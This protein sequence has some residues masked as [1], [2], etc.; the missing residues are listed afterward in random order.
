M[1]K[2]E[3]DIGQVLDELA[4]MPTCNA[5]EVFALEEEDFLE[6][7]YLGEEDGFTFLSNAYTD[8]GYL[9]DVEEETAREMGY[10]SAVGYDKNKVLMQEDEVDAFDE[11]CCEKSKREF[12]YDLEDAIIAKLDKERE[13]KAKKK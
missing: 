2:K 5:D 7:D 6:I 11:F 9:E 8:N 3:K 4:D 10:V 12:S 13:E 1:D